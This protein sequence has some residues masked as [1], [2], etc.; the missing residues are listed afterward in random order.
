MEQTHPEIS[1]REGKDV[2]IRQM[3][4]IYQNYLFGA[5]FSFLTAEIHRHLVHRARGIWNLVFCCCSNI[6]EGCVFEWIVD[7]SAVWVSS[8]SQWHSSCRTCATS[9]SSSTSSTLLATS[10]SRTRSPLRS[11]WPTVSSSSSMLLK[12]FVSSTSI[13]HSSHLFLTR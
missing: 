2:S 12:G 9:P 3:F 1:T 8:P 4:P 13:N 7:F 11:D 5:N 6:N 10:T